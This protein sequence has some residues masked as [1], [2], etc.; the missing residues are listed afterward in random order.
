MG[1]L[2]EIMEYG[3]TRLTLTCDTEG[4][5]TIQSFEH[6]DGYMGQR[7]L[8]M[9]AGWKDTSRDGGRVFLGPCCSGKAAR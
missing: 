3:A 9:A 4:C 2:I 8:A 1:L 6:P 5:P 7:G